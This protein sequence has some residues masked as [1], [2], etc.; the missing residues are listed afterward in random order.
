MLFSFSVMAFLNAQ[1]QRTFSIKNNVLYDATLTPNLGAEIVVGQR[2]FTQND[3]NAYTVGY[4]SYDLTTATV[5]L[6]P[7]AVWNLP[8]VSGA[9]IRHSIAIRTGAD[10]TTSMDELVMPQGAG[11]EQTAPAVW[12]TLSGMRLQGR[13]TI[14]GLYML[15]G[16]KVV[17]CRGK[18][19]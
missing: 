2:Y 18:S 14:P 16:K 4:D 19:F 13:P 10:D 15:N 11:R 6:T 5:A 1:A 3:A 9:P 7:V 8:T 12:H 17:V